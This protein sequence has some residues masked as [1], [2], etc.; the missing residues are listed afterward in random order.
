MTRLEQYF[1]GPF[2]VTLSGE[3]LTGFATDKVRALLAYLAVEGKRAH[4]REALAGLLWPNSSDSDAL[5][6]LR[7]AL[8]KLRQAL[9]SGGSEDKSSARATQ[10]NQ[11]DLLLVTTQT[12]QFEPGSYYLD[13][14][15]FRGLVK[16]CREHRHRKIEHCSTCHARLLHAADLYR[17]DFL[18]GFLLE[19]SEPFDEWLVLTREGLR[20]QALEV[21]AYLA[22]SYEAHSDHKQAL[23]YAYRQIEMEPW[24]E[25]VHRQAMRLLATSGQ[26]NAAIAQY[27]T[28]RR[29]LSQELGIEPEAE[30]VALYERIKTDY[31]PPA[32]DNQLLTNVPPQQAVFVGRGNELSGITE[33]L[34]HADCHLITLLGPGGVGKTRLAIQAADGQVGTYE[35]G[36]WFVPL[37]AV[38]TLTLLVSSIAQAIGLS[39][40]ATDE[41]QD[42]QLLRYL[43]D[44]EM[45]LVLDNF[46]QLV[47][48]GTGLLIDILENA[49]RIVM[50]V[51]SRERLGLQAEHLFDLRG[52]SLPES[53]V[54]L[55]DSGAVQLF[56]E[57][58]KQ[59]QSHFTLSP[60]NT[61]GVL[62][63]CR[64]VDG[65]PLAIL[66][67]AA[68]V[69]YSP[70]A[71]IA[72][73][74]SENLDFLTSSLRDGSPRHSS[75]RAVF[76]HSW[77]LLSNEE[78]QLFR[79]LSIFRG[80]WE[81]EEAEKVASAS[82]HSLLS[83]T[84]KSLLRQDQSGRYDMHE[85]LRQYASEQLE[86]APEEHG[87]T[88]ASHAACFLD[89]AERAEGDLRGSSQNNWLA[90]LDREHSNIRAA[91]EW[92]IERDD[93]R[94]RVAMSGA[95]WRFWYRRG[96]YK[97]GQEY[98]RGALAEAESRSNP[99]ADSKGEVAYSELARAYYG[100]GV[101]S[102]TQGDFEAAVGYLD[103]SLVLYR[104]LGDMLGMA[105]A[106]NVAGIVAHDRGDYDKA[107]AFYDQSLAAYRE[108]G[109]KLGILL[110]LNNSGNVARE[111]GDYATARTLLEEALAM[112][113][114]M[115][116][117][118][119][120]G[121]ALLGIGTVSWYQKDYPSANSVL[122]E[123]LG[124]LRQI[125]DKLAF[126]N[127]L[128]ALGRTAAS[129]GIPGRAARLWGAAAALREEVGSPL[130]PADRADYDLSVEAAR[131]EAGKESG[132][133][134]TQ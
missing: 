9:A 54:D 96:H 121:L 64:L 105:G 11:S 129:L 61:Q 38:N 57:K 36:V 83:L 128:E 106:L 111:R 12:V 34:D 14:D 37:V 85:V 114:E 46:E 117:D 88:L 92:A 65:M 120:V 41:Q 131:E 68:W 33:R 67:A 75:L 93:T 70:T 50:L 26:R 72:S 95:L 107:M 102:R 104:E 60:D 69:R 21:F 84:D 86:L 94:Y 7:Q 47:D 78:R 98:L 62:D 127:C 6:S 53:G 40:E 35:D 108:V 82:L 81:E 74:I 77:S 49:P 25:D 59:V 79:K 132:R 1:L 4:R 133:R 125:G 45:L 118:F 16:A 119:A 22:H 130:A 109:D 5:T 29:M 27:E 56:V 97:E 58:A 87:E 112:A 42:T 103:K 20:R 8:R 43:R 52:L 30:T 44:K 101:M 10:E 100:A 2:R 48:A 55:A 18:A 116:D 15:E 90:R 23:H 66:L 91:L 51:T 19:D 13:V 113:R 32:T 31:L 28:C 80:G 71:R 73:S 123:S 126:C 99:D 17:G 39:F 115:G 63:I 89:L 124:L 24:R 76:N 110:E 122:L 134:G 3:P